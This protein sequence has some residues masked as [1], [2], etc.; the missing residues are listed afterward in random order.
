[1]LK[2]RASL[3]GVTATVIASFADLR[4]DRAQKNAPVSRGVFVLSQYLPKI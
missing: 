1:M 3:P 4:Q 2:R